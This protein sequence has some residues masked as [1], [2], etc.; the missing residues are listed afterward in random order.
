[1]DENTFFKAYDSTQSTNEKLFKSIRVPLKL[2]RDPI[3]KDYPMSN[4]ITFINQEGES[5][6][7]LNS[8]EKMASHGK[9]QIKAR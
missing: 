3:I 2:K 1:M 5:E 6:W 4:Q 7:D 9:L 8:K